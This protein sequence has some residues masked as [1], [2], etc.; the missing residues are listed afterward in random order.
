[1][2]GAA[3]ADRRRARLVAVAPTPPGARQTLSLSTP[4]GAF[5]R[6]SAT[7]VLREVCTELGYNIVATT[8]PHPFLVDAYTNNIRKTAVTI[9]RIWASAAPI[10]ARYAPE[11]RKDGL[12]KWER[13]RLVDEIAVETVNALGPLLNKRGEVVTWRSIE[14]IAEGMEEGD[15]DF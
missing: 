14:M 6:I 10:V 11:L 1:M 7:V 15:W 8:D 4:A 2:V 9:V 13:K 12:P 5:R 3:P